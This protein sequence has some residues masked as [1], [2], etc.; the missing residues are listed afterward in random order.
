MF[1]NFINLSILSFTLSYTTSDK[2]YRQHGEL[3]DCGFISRQ[4]IKEISDDTTRKKHKVRE[5]AIR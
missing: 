2:H 5:P 1:C 4:N 3:M